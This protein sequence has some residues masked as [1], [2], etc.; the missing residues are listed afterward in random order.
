MRHQQT[1]K[2]RRVRVLLKSGVVIVDHFEF[3]KSKWIHLRR[4]GKVLQQNVES[5]TIFTH[6]PARRAPKE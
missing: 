3:R 4:H 5:M 1:Y 6:Q 2:G